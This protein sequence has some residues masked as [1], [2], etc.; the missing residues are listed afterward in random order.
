MVLD[1]SNGVGAIPMKKI[2]PM[3]R[4][5]VDITLINTRIDEPKKVNQECG[6]EFVHKERMAPTEI[7][8]FMP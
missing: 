6:A 1:C 4:D 3:I 5:F 7:Q 8:E 2:A